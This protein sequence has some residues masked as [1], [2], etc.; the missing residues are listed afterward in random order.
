[1]AWMQ[2]NG[3]LSKW[4]VAQGYVK[5]ERIGGTA[6]FLAYAVVNDGGVPGAGTGDG[7]Y[8]E[9]IPIVR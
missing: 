7:S 4:K 2:I 3:A 8:V 5:V 6:P 9:M 1:G